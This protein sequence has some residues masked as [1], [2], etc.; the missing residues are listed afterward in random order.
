MSHNVI[1][2]C[3]SNIKDLSPEYVCALPR[4]LAVCLDKPGSDHFRTAAV[5]KVSEGCEGKFLGV[6]MSPILNQ[7]QTHQAVVVA[8]LVEACFNHLEEDS[9]TRFAK[10]GDPVYMCVKTDAQCRGRLSLKTS[11]TSDPVGYFVQSTEKYIGKVMLQRH[12]VQANGNAPAAPRDQYAVQAE[13][14][15]RTLGVEVV[16]NPENFESSIKKISEQLSGL[17]LQRGNTRG[18]ATTIAYN[19]LLANHPATT[20]FAAPLDLSGIVNSVQKRVAQMPAGTR[21]SQGIDE[22]LL[23]FYNCTEQTKTIHPT[24]SALMKVYKHSQSLQPPPS[25]GP[26][27]HVPLPVI[28]TIVANCNVS[29]NVAIAT[30]IELGLVCS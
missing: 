15:S 25:L 7:K 19:T 18:H 20:T 16:V 2:V 29:A 4:G 5:A 3:I 13:T 8:G 27:V 28:K 10:L 1:S 17:P 21:K 30:A 6:T 12:I 26:V 23:N 11:S 14:A 24:L 22:F 9:N